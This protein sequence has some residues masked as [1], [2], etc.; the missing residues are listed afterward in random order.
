MNKLLLT[1]L[2]GIFLCQIAH[3]SEGIEPIPGKTDNS[4]ILKMEMT[5]IP[6]IETETSETSEQTNG[7]PKHCYESSSTTRREYNSSH[8]ESR[9]SSHRSTRTK[10]SRK[11]SRSRSSRRTPYDRRRNPPRYNGQAEI[12]ALQ[13]YERFN[14]M[15]QARLPYPVNYYAPTNP[16]SLTNMNYN[17]QQWNQYERARYQPRPQRR[18]EP[19]PTTE[20]LDRQLMQ[21]KM[22]GDT[23]Q[24]QNASIQTTWQGTQQR[25][26]Q[27]PQYYQNPTQQYSNWGN[28]TQPYI[29]GKIVQ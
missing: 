21:Y 27:Q 25:I 7:S 20:E 2:I 17:S 5:N 1:T 23:Q 10:H 12:I 8:R 16:R 14:Q 28:N 24:T 6:S 11:S 4:E 9:Y 15:L 18:T 19:M 13:A 26:T 22:G 3:S 29:S